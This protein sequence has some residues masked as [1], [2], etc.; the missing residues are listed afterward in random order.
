MNVEGLTRD[1]VKSHLQVYF[2]F[3]FSGK[4]FGDTD[5]S[6]LRFYGLLIKRN[7]P[8]RSTKW[9]KLSITHLKVS[10]GGWKLEPL[11]PL[12]WIHLSMFHLIISTAYWFL[13]MVQNSFVFK[14]IHFPYSSHLIYQIV[15]CITV[16][17]TSVETTTCIEAIPS[18]VQ[19]WVITH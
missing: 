10:N 19:K 8:N 12:V 1:Q 7:T 9:L 18:D 17:G 13:H 3:S 2:P 15:D 4:I 14:E 6:V 11:L 5:T 16:P